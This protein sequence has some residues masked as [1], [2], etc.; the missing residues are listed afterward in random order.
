MF[1]NYSKTAPKLTKG[2]IETVISLDLCSMD[3]DIEDYLD[4]LSGDLRAQAQILVDSLNN[5]RQ[6]AQKARLEA[7]M[8]T[9]TI[10]QRIHDIAEARWKMLPIAVQREHDILAMDIAELQWHLKQ[11]KIELRKSKQKLD[12]AKTINRRVKADID[13][14]KEHSPLVEGK[15]RLEQTAIHEIKNVQKQ[16]DESLE[17]TKMRLEKA[18]AEYRQKSETMKAERDQ[19]TTKLQKVMNTLAVL[20]ADLQKKEADKRFFT[21]RTETAKIRIAAQEDE[22]HE[23][24]T[25]AEDMRKQERHETTRIEALRI[26]IRNLDQE[27]FDL[28]N[29]RN[30]LDEATKKRHE[31]CQL[32]LGELKK[33]HK[34]TG[35]TVISLITSVYN[36]T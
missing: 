11:E 1:Q 15:L 17:L 2:D 8:A 20:N 23:L 6:Q 16:Q 36:R 24:Q 13:F 31:E 21:E 35:S 3:D 32:K 33:T 4:C 29:E 5:D 14:N 9:T 22:I 10:N 19:H 26:E 30:A 25:A 7:R 12:Y 18:E 27:T 28:D 34:A